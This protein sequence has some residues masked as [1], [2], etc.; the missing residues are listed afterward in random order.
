MRA[1]LPPG[2]VPIEQSPVARQQLVE[3][4]VRRAVDLLADR[5][6]ADAVAAP[7]SSA[8]RSLAGEHAGVGSEAADLVPEPAPALRLE[9]GAAGR[10]AASA[11]GLGRELAR[12]DQPSAAT[13]SA[14]SVGP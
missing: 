8:Y 9:L 5:L 2:F 1:S 13:A 10:S 7:T 6:G 11:S 14:S 12:V 3:P 4:L